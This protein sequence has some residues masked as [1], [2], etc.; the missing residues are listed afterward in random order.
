MKKYPYFTYLLLLGSGVLIG[1]AAHGWILDGSQSGGP[2]HAS[3]DILIGAK[4]GRV[5]AD[6]SPRQDRSHRDGT[7]K[8]DSRETDWVQFRKTYKTGDKLEM[9]Q[10]FSEWAK[11]DPETALAEA[12]KWGPSAMDARLEIL[13][14]WSRMNPGAAAEYLAASPQLL[15][16]SLNLAG[17]R[18]SERDAGFA[19]IAGEWGKQDPG[20]AFAWAKT[21]GKELAVIESHAL[22]NPQSAIALTDHLEPN[23]KVAGLEA[24]GR[25][26]AALK[27]EE[28]LNWANTLKGAAKDQ[29]LLKI[30]NVVA[31]S[32]PGQAAAI[33]EMISDPSRKS[34]AA[35]QLIESWAS[36]SPDEALR[37]FQGDCPEAVKPT[38]VTRLV[39]AMSRQDP[40]AG[41]QVVKSLPEGSL[42]RD[43][44]AASFI[45]HSESG[46][47]MSLLT[48]NEEIGNDA[49]RWQTLAVL[50][51]R[52]K[53]EDP[54]AASAYLQ[55]RPEFGQ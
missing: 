23:Q 13:K 39:A 29:V 30:G 11:S 37:W 34:M 22:E 1:M 7:S 44:A 41:L 46:D 24:I 45:Q 27:P 12:C 47:F 14:I 36:S 25:A 42:L 38:A 16:K 32:E 33:V 20:G 50:I 48:I 40:E 8:A 49:E 53:E 6:A 43:K 4:S 55:E 52:W 21:V 9:L 5:A 19:I 2:S 26:W 3:D 15:S 10:Y 54:A 35:D 18:Q 28:A 31:L 17:S 51:S